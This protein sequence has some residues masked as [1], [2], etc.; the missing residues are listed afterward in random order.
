M[1]ANAVVG[2]AKEVR[3]LYAEGGSD[4]EVAAHL[5]ITIKEFYKQ[6]A[7]SRPFALLVEM[8]RTLSMA[9]WEKQARLNVKNKTFN[10]PLWVFS[11]K[12]KYGWADKVETTSTNENLN[13]SLDSLR[14]DIDRKLKRLYKD[15]A[16][17]LTAAQEVLQPVDPLENEH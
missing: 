3:D 6:M 2:W 17:G 9:W 10:T 7:D 1:S 16:A 4:A 11:M 5:N 15:N 14:S 13:T 8:G 12:N